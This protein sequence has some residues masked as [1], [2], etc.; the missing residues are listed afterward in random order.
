MSWAVVRSRLCEAASRGATA[1]D[2]RII[3]IKWIEYGRIGREHA[4]YIGDPRAREPSCA[5]VLS[6]TVIP[7]HWVVLQLTLVQLP[8]NFVILSSR[9]CSVARMEVAI[10]MVRKMWLRRRMRFSKR[11]SVNPRRRLAVVQSTMTRLC[12]V[13]DVLGMWSA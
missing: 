12:D 5:A 4:V 8:F 13:L 11:T 1:A 2:I 7:Y 10:P 9:S 3:L 6:I